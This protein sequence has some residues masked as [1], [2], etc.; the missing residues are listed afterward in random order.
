M[1]IK[2]LLNKMKSI[3]GIYIIFGIS[4]FIFILAL[5][6][7]FENKHR[8]YILDS[9][10]DVYPSEVKEIYRYLVGAGC[11]GDIYFKVELDSGIKETK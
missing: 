9:I 8:E 3:Y 7:H 2:E 5:I 1:K 6:I 11:N 10:Y 4:I